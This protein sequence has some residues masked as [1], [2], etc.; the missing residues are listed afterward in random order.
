M[1]FTK[2]KKDLQLLYLDTS[3]LDLRVTPEQFNQCLPSLTKVYHQS[4]SSDCVLRIPK[5][6][7]W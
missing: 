4:R 7:H 5:I 3:N 1:T 6:F 2:T